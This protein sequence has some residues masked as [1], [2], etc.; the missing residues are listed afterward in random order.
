MSPR[1]TV[2]VLGGGSWG[3]TVAHLSAHN[4]ETHLFSR[5]PEVVET[6]N[7]RHENPVYL[8]GFQLHPELRA[9]GDIAEVVANA[10]VVVMGVTSSGVADSLDALDGLLDPDTAIVSLVK[11]LDPE[12]GRRVTELISDRF[13]DNPVGV[14]TGPNLAKEILAGQAAAAVLAFDDDQLAARLQPL[15]ATERFRVYTNTDVAGCELGGAL[16]NVIALA[17]GMADGLGAGDNTRAA[18]ITRGLHELTQLGVAMGGR[19]ETFGGL[20]GMG[21]LVATCISPQSRNRRVGEQLGLGRPLEEIVEEMQE[22]AEGIRSAAVVARLGREHG[23]EL[24]ICNEVC[25]VIK[26]E[27]SAKEAYS[28]LL[29]RPRLSEF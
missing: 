3:T 7:E 13:P 27:R 8:P 1:L 29:S 22:V 11:G 9:S 28:G 6:I 5:R 25:A 10:D 14:L 24:P 4:A 23:L 16:K 12:T 26:G 19:A 17:S 18:V 20:T 21:D 2:A 15:F